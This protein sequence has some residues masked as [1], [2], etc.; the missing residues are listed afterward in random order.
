[1]S[2]IKE[3]AD[4][5]QLMKWGTMDSISY[6]EVLSA[7]ERHQKILIV[8]AKDSGKN[9]V[10]HAVVNY[11]H[12]LRKEPF[13][14]PSIEG[15]P[16]K[17]FKNHLR[18]KGLK[19]LIMGFNSYVASIQYLGNSKTDISELTEYLIPHFDII[20]DLR[21][22]DGHRVICN[23]IKGRKYP[24]YVYTNPKFDKYLVA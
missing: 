6:K 3:L 23:L 19:R 18:L 11:M 13:V 2:H 21:N 7:L 15:V 12:R 17:R 22:L 20:I 16:T 24:N 9:T 14:I 1:M 5:E 8:A 4:L 10:Q